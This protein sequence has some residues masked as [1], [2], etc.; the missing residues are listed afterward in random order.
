MLVYSRYDRGLSSAEGEEFNVQI[1]SSRQRSFLDLS[2][3]GLQPGNGLNLIPS[4]RNG[5]QAL[6]QHSRPGKKPALLNKRDVAGS[7]PRTTSSLLDMSRS[8]ACR[9]SLLFP[10][11]AITVDLWDIP[12]IVSAAFTFAEC[13]SHTKMST[14]D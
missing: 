3:S 7:Q 13:R 4:R 6:P 1:Q 12:A 9:N 11:S 5:A 8:F 2:L 10:C 14:A